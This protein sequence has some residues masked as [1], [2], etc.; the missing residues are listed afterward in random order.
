MRTVR[1]WSV[2]LGLLYATTACS[3]AQGRGDERA[4]LIVLNKS[5]AQAALVNPAT[6]EVESLLE[7][8]QGPHEV[9]ASPDGRY[10]Y[11][12]NYGLYGAAT[13]GHKPEN[14]PGNTITVLDLMNR[15]VHATWDLGSFSQPHG[16]AVS[17]S[18]RLV[19]VTCEGA[20]AVLELDAGTG[21]LTRI[22]KTNQNASHMIV[23]S[24]DEKKLY[25]SNIRSG[26]VSVI[27]RTRPTDGT[28]A[29]NI[30]TGASPEG[31]ALSP[32]GREVWVGNRGA[33]SIAVIDTATD[34]VT[35]S[36]SS[37]GK[38]PIRVKFTPDGK[39]AWV[40][41]AENNTVCVLDGATH[42]LLA[43]IETGA[44]PVG[45]VIPPDGK[46]VFIAATRANQVVV[47]DRASRQI[48]KRLK[49]GAEPD[50]MAWAAA[51]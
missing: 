18:G 10:A 11:V 21:K 15:K 12:T 20:Q 48:V 5:D 37:G 14:E 9:A 16:I 40:S 23:A 32:D 35:A 22:W 8:G 13:P 46:R 43:T 33:N 26:T 47:V 6:Y 24:Q 36:F 28:A 50:G 30:A 38:A 29:P 41:N 25:V 42:A 31:I 39:E 45:T 3:F 17:R 34:K 7:T 4:L 1:F 2:L 19:W 49:T 27:D 44:G 51:P